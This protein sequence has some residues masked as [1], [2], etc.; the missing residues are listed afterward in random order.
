MDNLSPAILALIIAELYAKPPLPAFI[1]ILSP[2][3]VK[4]P[5]I[6]YAAVSR[7]WQTLAEVHT[8]SKLKLKS[9]DLSTFASVF[10][11]PR[12]RALLRRLEF[13][14]EMPTHGD[15][16]DDH[17]AN[18]AASTASLEALTSLLSSWETQRD[19]EESRIASF[20][21]CLSVDW[22]GDLG[23]L[24]AVRSSAAR[25]YLAIDESATLEVVKRAT[26]LSVASSTGRALHPTAMCRVVACMPHLE[27]L[28]LEVLDPANKRLEMR[29]SHRLA[30]ASGLDSLTLRHLR[31]LSLT[32]ETTTEPYNHSFEC[33]DLE[34]GTGV[35]PLCKT[36]RRIGH[37]TPLTELKLDTFLVAK[38]LFSDASD[39]STSWSS[40][41]R[42]TIRA[43]PVAPN[44][45]WYYTG[46]P[47]D[48][49]AGS[50]TP[51]VDDDGDDSESDAST[52]PDD[53]PDRDA[54][55]NGTRPS[56]AW[57]TVPDSDMLSPLL[58]SLAG[59][60]QQ[61]PNLQNGALSISHH[62]P[63]DVV[64][65]CV[66]PGFAI[67]EPPDGQTYAPVQVRTAKIWVSDRTTW[68]LPD[69]VRAAWTEWLSD[70]AK[71][72]TGTWP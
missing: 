44:G 35:D 48:V 15:S 5:R 10:A 13:T 54:I 27:A 29:K 24:D 23:Y 34:D 49:E 31:W 45:R 22:A 50:D 42:F 41:H 8:L 57:R 63:M 26:S 72:E 4:P 32:R 40:L 21:V 43:A 12:R 25:R 51:I 67:T 70:G 71:F 2:P 1:S 7:R 65:Q 62:E 9:S 18:E 14:V 59:A 37:R 66:S 60:V 39:E 47:A 11:D 20:E 33:G 56:H 58:T 17:A 64:V 38:D 53:D 69:P 61:M 55:A 19:A 28:S 6:Q 30:L 46:N 68:K 52:E 36:I 3:P 16:R